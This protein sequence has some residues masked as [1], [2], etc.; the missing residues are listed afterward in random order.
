MGTK[1]GKKERKV[2]KIKEI[3]IKVKELSKWKRT[4]GEGEKI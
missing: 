3:E 4:G 2:K 1:N